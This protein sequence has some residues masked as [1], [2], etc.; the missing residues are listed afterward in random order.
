METKYFSLAPAENNRF[1][2]LIR[3]VFGVI[4]FAVAIFWFIFNIRSAKAD[5][6]IWITIIFLSGFGLYQIWSGLGRATRYIEI[7]MNYILLKK[8]PV[9]PP[10]RINVEEIEKI[11][12]FPLN[13]IIFLNSGKKINL[14]FGT[15]YPEMTADIKDAIIVYADSKNII[16]DLKSEQV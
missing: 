16:L 5:G 6:I 4:C 1:V 14:R 13:M 7:G 8:N 10:V 12:L 9:L 11:E 2:N 15:T 3:I